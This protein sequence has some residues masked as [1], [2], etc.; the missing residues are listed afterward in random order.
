MDKKGLLI[1][2]V[3]IDGS[4]KTTQAELLYKWLLKK[5]YNVYNLYNQPSYADWVFDTIAKSKGYTNTMELFTPTIVDFAVAIDK[6]SDY[7]IY[8]DKLY[9]NNAIII[10]QRYSYC[11]IA[12]AI[13]SNVKYMNILNDIYDFIP[14]PDIVFYMDLPT[15]IAVDRV[16]K[17]GIDLETYEDL[18]EYKNCYE[19]LQCFKNFVKI[20]ANKSVEEISHVVQEY[21]NNYLL[22]SNY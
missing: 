21:F 22:S 10:T 6:I 9:S 1:S 15:E 11:K 4:G 5:K 13:Q 2:F 7:F 17:R 14:K 3:G 20:D 12:S 18:Q 8:S 19:N 16:L